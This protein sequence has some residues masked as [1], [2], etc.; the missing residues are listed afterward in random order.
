MYRSRERKN[1]RLRAGGATGKAGM[2]PWWRQSSERSDSTIHDLHEGA[3]RMLPATV[4]HST[5]RKQLTSKKQSFS[6]ALSC[7]S[8]M[9]AATCRSCSGARLRGNGIQPPTAALRKFSAWSV[10]HSRARA[11]RTLSL[12]FVICAVRMLGCNEAKQ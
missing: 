9:I 3:A 7:D 6:L 4:L 2:G 10:A 8:A 11:F 1:E 5:K 12:F